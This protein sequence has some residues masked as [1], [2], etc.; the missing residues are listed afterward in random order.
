VLPVLSE[1]VSEGPQVAV[2]GPKFVRSDVLVEPAPVW[3]VV[4]GPESAN[5]NYWSPGPDDPVVL[6]EM[7]AGFG[8]FA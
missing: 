4:S 5:F 2:S 8:S 7:P 1:S 6:P 3:R